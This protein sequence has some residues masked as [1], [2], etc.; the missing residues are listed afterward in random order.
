MVA[1]GAGEFVGVNAPWKMSEAHTPIGRE[2]PAI[3]A[4]R[5][6]ILLGALGLSAEAIAGLAAAGAFGKARA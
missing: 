3:G 1:D 4:H 6:E 5:D 2:V